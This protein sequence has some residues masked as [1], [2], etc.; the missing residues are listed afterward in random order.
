MAVM[1]FQFFLSHKTNKCIVH[2]FQ[3]NILSIGG[4]TCSAC[5]SGLEKYLNKQDGVINASV[6]LVLSQALIE[7]ND[8]LTIDDLNRFIKEA[9]FASLGIYNEQKEENHK[10]ENITLIIFGI[11]SIIV[12]YISMSHMIHLLVIPFLHMIDYP[13]LVLK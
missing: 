6:N 8:S 9:G 7:Y 1:S 2:L 3:Q 13:M 11:L 5:S 10:K 4:M 12:L